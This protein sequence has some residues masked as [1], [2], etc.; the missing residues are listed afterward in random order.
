[1]KRILLPDERAK[2]WERR[3]VWTVGTAAVVLGVG[4]L[5]KV[6]GVIR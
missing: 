4:Y 2:R 1:M 6:L 5:L 3:W